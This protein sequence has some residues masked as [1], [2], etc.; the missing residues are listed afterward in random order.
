MK[1]IVEGIMINEDGWLAIKRG[2]VFKEQDC[3]F[4][5]IS[6][7][8]SRCGDWCPHFGDQS[9]VDDSPENEFGEI[10]SLALCNGTILISLSDVSDMRLKKE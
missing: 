5:A 2:G 9:Y 1:R 6:G 4:C 7:C 10:M 8:S 3:P